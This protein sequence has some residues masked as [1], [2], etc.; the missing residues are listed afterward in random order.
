MRGSGRPLSVTATATTISL[1]RGASD[2]RASMA[3]K[4]LRTKAASLWPSGTSIAVP[5]PPAEAALAWLKSQPGGQDAA[6]WLAFSGGAPLQALKY[7]EE[8]STWDRLLKSPTPADEREGLERLAEVLQ[9]VAYDRAFYLF[10]SAALEDARLA[11]KLL[12]G[13]EGV[14]RRYWAREGGK[15]VNKS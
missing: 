8:A 14:E 7:A 10:D 3:S 5:I 2:T 6:R 11:W 12:A 9:K 1:A 4:W 13:R 15:W